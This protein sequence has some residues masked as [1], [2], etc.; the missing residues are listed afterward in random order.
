M[1]DVEQ[2]L[3]FMGQSPA[4]RDFPQDERLLDEVV[5]VYTQIYAAGLINF[6]ESRWWMFPGKNGN[7]LRHDRQAVNLFASFLKACT[8]AGAAFDAPTNTL[9][10]RLVW[11]LIRLSYTLPKED[12][13]KRTTLPPPDDGI[14]VRNRVRVVEALLSG[15]F[16]EVNPLSP[17]VSDH[18]SGR[19][20]EFE[21]WFN[22]A[23][24]IR[25]KDQPQ[26]REA[27]ELVLANMRRLL[28][29]RENRDILY[30][31]AILREHGPKHEPGYEKQLPDH[32]DESE[33]RF[34]L[35][36]ASRFLRNQAK[37]E[38]GLTNVSR[39][40]CEI[41]VMAYVEPGVNIRRKK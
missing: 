14:E 28:G 31:I 9:E 32:L 5:D 33:D 25:F 13:A 37:A 26:Y 22:L 30:S 29:G 35:A 36:V 39:R 38:V 34:K 19:E 1:V 2:I 12:N 10:A 8:D 18:N 15:D 7:P 16:I 3:A 6:F 24:Y 20:Q 21:F 4:T 23:E 41:S 40:L 11:Q 27:K 17:C